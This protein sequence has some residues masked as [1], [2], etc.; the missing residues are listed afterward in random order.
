MSSSR[1]LLMVVAVDFFE[2]GVHHVFSAGVAAFG[3]LAFS[4]AL[5]GIVHR[6]AQLH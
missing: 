5:L 2:L 1:R 6:L 4:G 3:A